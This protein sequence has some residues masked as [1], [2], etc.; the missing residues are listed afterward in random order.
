MEVSGQLHAPA[1]LPP[2][3]NWIGGWVSPRDELDAVGKRKISFRCLESN[4]SSSAIRHVARRYTDSAI[5]DN[6]SRSKCY[7]YSYNILKQKTVR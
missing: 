1:A 6:I 3:N 4:L 2:A 5:P 7:Q